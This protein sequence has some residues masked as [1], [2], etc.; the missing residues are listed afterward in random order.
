[1]GLNKAACISDSGPGSHMDGHETYMR[2]RIAHNV[3]QSQG[4]P[5][6]GGQTFNGFRLHLP[7]EQALA[8]L[9]SVA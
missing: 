8:G 6:H 7:Y 4:S 9:A 5:L 1:M 2:G 3:L